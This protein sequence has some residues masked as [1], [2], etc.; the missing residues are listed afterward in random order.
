MKKITLFVLLCFL[1]SCKTTSTYYYQVYKTKSETVKPSGNTIVFEDNNCKISYNLW[2]ENGNAGFTFY[3]KTNEV[4]YL[5]L[6]ESFYIING[7]AYDYYQNRIFTNSN[8][9]ATKTSKTTGFSQLGWLSLSSYTSNTVATNSTS[10][11]QIVEAKVVAIPSKSSKKVSEFNINQTII[12]DCDLLRFPTSKQTSNKGFSED[13][14]PLKF[15]NIITYKLGDKTNKVKNDFYVSEITNIADK[16]AFRQEKNTFCDQKG[17]GVTNVFI[18][19][20][21]DKFYLTYTKTQA[22]TWKY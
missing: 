12:R 16:D 18:N 11:V 1:T 7:S 20:A 8:N 2:A 5:L 6:D 21:P 15:Y 13:S 17:G 14:S 10:G 19:S 9:T 22:D 3:N 4:I